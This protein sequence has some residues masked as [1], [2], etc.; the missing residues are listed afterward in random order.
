MAFG[1]RH[2]L[3]KHVKREHSPS[4]TGKARPAASTSRARAAS[5]TAESDGDGASGASGGASAKA[6]TAPKRKRGG[7]AD[8]ALSASEK[9]SDAEG[10]D[11]NR[12]KR[13]TKAK[14]PQSAAGERSTGKPSA[15]LRRSVSAS[16]LSSQPRTSAT[17]ASVGTGDKAMIEKSTTCNWRA[18]PSEGTAAG[19]GAAAAV[20]GSTAAMAAGTATEGGRSRPEQERQRPSSGTGEVRVGGGDALEG[21]K[22]VVSGAAVSGGEKAKQALADMLVASKSRLVKSF[23]GSLGGGGGGHGAVSAGKTDRRAR[24]RSF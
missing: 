16:E 1:H 24:S 15:G 23:A 12:K 8:A 2:T 4:K 5:A 20:A 19:E 13:A 7:A 21:S 14:L 11:N 18:L 17:R 22:S 6:A 9:A 10:A 3:V